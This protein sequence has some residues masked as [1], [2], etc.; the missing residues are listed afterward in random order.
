MLHSQLEQHQPLKSSPST[1]IKCL[2]IRTFY[3]RVLRGRLDRNE[4]ATGGLQKTIEVGGELLPVARHKIARNG[5][6]EK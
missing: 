1:Q 5:E 6:A 2:F 4:A 3:I